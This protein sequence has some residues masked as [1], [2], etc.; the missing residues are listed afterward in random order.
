MK[1]IQIISFIKE[2]EIKIN[3][4]EKQLIREGEIGG[5]RYFRLDD[6]LIEFISLATP[7]F[8][9]DKVSFS[10]TDYR[11]I[12]IN[13]MSAEVEEHLSQSLLQRDSL[14]LTNSLDYKP[15]Y[16]RNMIQVNLQKSQQLLNLSLLIW[17]LKEKVIMSTLTGHQKIKLLLVGETQ[18]DQLV[19]N[20]V[21]QTLNELA[22]IQNS[23][24]LQLHLYTP[25]ELTLA[26]LADIE[27]PFQEYLNYED[28]KINQYQKIYPYSDICYALVASE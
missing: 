5:Q 24:E 4:K 22:S 9:Q 21:V 11:I 25:R 3:E 27:D 20:L 23:K 18:E 7:T 14:I 19:S 13:N 10:K 12:L 1:K 2:E 8:M 26:E 17:L 15:S 6:Y 16:F 28:F